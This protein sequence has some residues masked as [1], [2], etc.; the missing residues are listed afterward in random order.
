[1]KSRQ[2]LRSNVLCLVSLV[3]CLTSLTVSAVP[4]VR[5]TMALEKGWNAVY[6]EST[7]DNAACEEFFR[8]TSVTS[9]AAYLSEADAATAQYD[10]SGDEIVQK[11]VS[12]LHWFKEYPGSSTLSAIVGGRVYLVYAGAKENIEFYGV[13]AVPKMTWRKATSTNDLF[14][15]AGVS[16]ANS[17]I[18]ATTYFGEGPFGTVKA[19]QAI[20]TL[21]GEDP[22]APE[23]K[24]ASVFGKAAQVSG[25]KAYALTATRSGEW[26]GVIGI[27]K[28]SALTFSAGA[29][30]ASVKI[31]NCGTKDHVFALQMVGDE[32]ADPE[33]FPPLRRQLPRADALSAPEYTNVTESS[34][35]EVALKPGEAT[36][37]VFALDRSQLVDGTTN[38]AILV[39]SDPTTQMRVR[40]PVSVTP[41]EADAVRYPTGL[42]VGELTL[43]RVSGLDDATPTPVAA[44][45]QLKMSVMMH[46][47]EDGKCT[48]LQRVAAGVDTNGAARLFMDLANVPPEV[49]GA[50]RLST[51]MMS[52][53]MPV[54]A[55]AAGSAFGDDAD[56]SW[57]VDAKARDNPFR[58]AW[59]PDH[60]GKKADYSGDL[61][62]GVELWSVSNRLDFSWHEQGNRALPANF[63][64]NAD[65]T[66]SGVVTWSVTGLIANK[67][68]KSVGTFAL[69]RVFKAKKVE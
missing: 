22:N 53:D 2:C 66:T 9:V 18:L 27:D 63:P 35:W 21:G 69:K 20:Y 51:V 36:E 55:A 52:V 7:P 60:D 67:P 11:P 32:A 54:V 26:P 29:S 1:M 24:N 30:Y 42:W 6:V 41:D 15:I 46:V 64:Y 23:L 49:E 50:K 3:S 31:R 61:P 48:L 56:F 59:H 5:E 10:A 68:I 28:G 37:Q 8:G 47:G 58:H 38:G 16:S 44:G 39:I 12:Y 45:G 4:H 57:T 19:A 40:L 43:A 14:N 13:P 33:Q 62:E 65:E 25:G 17:G 34:A